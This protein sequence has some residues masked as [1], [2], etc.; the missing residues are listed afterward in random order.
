MVV[1]L[2][3][4]RRRYDWLR[5]FSC[6]MSVAESPGVA[7]QGLKTEWLPPGRELFRGLMLYLATE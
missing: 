1:I 5:L 6:L 2:T 4:T 3:M 7:S